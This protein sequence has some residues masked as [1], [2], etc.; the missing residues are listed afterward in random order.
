MKTKNGTQ[1]VPTRAGTAADRHDTNTLVYEYDLVQRKRRAQNIFLISKIAPYK[2]LIFSAGLFS[3]IIVNFKVDRWD[4][5]PTFS[6]KT[7]KPYALI[8]LSR[9]IYKRF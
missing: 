9:T 3:S 5:T 8:R 4:C 2:P 7:L 1:N 6:K